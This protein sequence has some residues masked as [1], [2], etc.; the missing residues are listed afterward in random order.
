MTSQKYGLSCNGKLRSRNPEGRP[1]RS[2]RKHTFH[3][4]ES[5]GGRRR[6]T[7]DAKTELKERWLLERPLI[8]KVQSEPHLTQVEYFQFRLGAGAIDFTS[9]VPEVARRID[10]GTLVEIH[11]SDVKRTYFGAEFHDMRDP[12]GGRQYDG[13]GKTW[14]VNGRMIA[15]AHAGRQVEDYIG[16]RLTDKPDH[17]SVELQFH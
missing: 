4:K 1:N 11:C 8:Q 9:H 17:L 2:R 16:S 14:N 13:R 15:G 3:R 6:T 7:A 10:Y 12:L 5:L